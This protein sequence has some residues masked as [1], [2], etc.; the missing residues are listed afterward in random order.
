[1]G[2]ERDN[3]VLPILVQLVPVIT[4]II[5]LGAVLSI[6]LRV[7]VVTLVLGCRVPVVVLGCWRVVFRG[8]IVLGYVL[9]RNYWVGH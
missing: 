1:M 4:L 5:V 3:L 9:L 7:D 6:L 8:V 2:V